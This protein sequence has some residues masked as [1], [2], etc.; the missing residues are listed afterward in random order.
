MNFLNL[1]SSL[2][3][4]GGF[5]YR[6]MGMT[7]R[8]RHYEEGRTRVATISPVATVEPL[9]KT[10]FNDRYTYKMLED[11]IGERYKGGYNKCNKGYAFINLTEPVSVIPFYQGKA[12]LEAHQHGQ[13]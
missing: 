8:K 12:A 1:A 10:C 6:L 13:T 11:V 4:K 9:H 2:R 7:W 5:L 3:R